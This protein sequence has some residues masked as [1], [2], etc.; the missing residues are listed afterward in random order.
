M[1]VSG[2]GVMYLSNLQRA[3]E[4]KQEQAAAK[5]KEEGQQRQRVAALES[6]GLKMIPFAISKSMDGTGQLHVEYPQ[7][8]FTP[9]NLFAL[10]SPIGMFL[11]IR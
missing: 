2:C 1:R 11:S 4:A 9:E 5:A 8:N 3:R 6:S 10:G 7:L